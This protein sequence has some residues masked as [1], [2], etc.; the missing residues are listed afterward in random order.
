M[1]TRVLDTPAKRIS[2]AL[3]IAT[4]LIL[5]AA[6]AYIFLRSGAAQPAN[7]P[8]IIA[9]ARAYTH[10]LLQ[11]HA[12]I[13]PSVPLQTLLDQGLLE[14]ADVGSFQGL[15]ANISL[16]ARASEG[17]QAVLMRVH[18][19]DGTDLVLLADGT[20]MSVRK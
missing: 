9:A 11:N 1:N 18:L 6:A 19:P 20:A 3:A 13:P 17:P 4:G 10:A 12:P 14:P 5:L 15:D 2:I 8:K 16:T 7:G